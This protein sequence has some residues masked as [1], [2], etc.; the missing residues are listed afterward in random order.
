MI[1]DMQ[2]VVNRS[3]FLVFLFF[4]MFT[5]TKNAQ[6]YTVCM[7]YNEDNKGNVPERIANYAKTNVSNVVFAFSED[8]LSDI[9]I[10][11]R[12]EIV[13]AKPYIIWNPLE[14]QEAIYYFPLAIEDRVFA[15][16]AVLDTEDGLMVQYGTD[17]S[18]QLNEINYLNENIIFYEYNGNLLAESKNECAVIYNFSI[19]NLKYTKE[20]KDLEQKFYALPYEEK[21]FVVNTK[22]KHLKKCFHREV[23]E[24]EAL[25]MRA[26]GN[27]ILHKP[28]G[29]YGYGMCWAAA[30]ATVVNY[31]N[32]SSVTPFDI[33]NRLSIPYNRG[34]TIDDIH[35]GLDLY[36]VKYNKKLSMIDEWNIIKKNIDNKYPIVAFLTC[37]DNIL[38]PHTV[39][40]YGYTASKDLTYWDSLLDDEK[41]GT[42]AVSYNKVGSKFLAIS[43]HSF[44]WATTVA[45]YVYIS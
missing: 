44:S 23:N 5:M 20:E 13:V 27:P 43:G 8:G 45:K 41:G 1:N 7:Q 34:G 40:V 19:D 16:L 18:E 9:N 28:M 15:V 11:Q 14:N 26:K 6:A 17:I 38:V 30:V 31:R 4:L 21:V 36:G 37:N 2:K 32:D 42:K 35:N 22:I 3:I 10:G 12:T 29:Q 39:T 24:E 25:N 33:C